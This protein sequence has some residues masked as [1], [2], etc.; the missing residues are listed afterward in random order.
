MLSFRVTNFSNTNAS[1]THKFNMDLQQMGF[2]LTLMK[3][4]TKVKNIL[5]FLSDFFH[6]K[7]VTFTL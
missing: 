5:I 1:Q 7:L 6:R 4:D 2:K 3:F